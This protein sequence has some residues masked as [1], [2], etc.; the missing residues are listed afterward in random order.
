MMTIE[1][2]SNRPARDAAETWAVSEA[3]A[4]L[5]ELIDEAIDDGPQVIA[6]N[7]SR[8]VVV[9]AVSE[10]EQKS[11]RSINLADFF[12]ASRLRGANIR[13]ERT[14]DLPREVDLST[15]ISDFQAADI[16]LFNPWES[17]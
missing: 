11:K 3:K 10:W 8:A 4:H 14:M 6:R 17:A 16:E 5:S 12:A 7:G 13:V 2:N 15:F 9:V 1:T